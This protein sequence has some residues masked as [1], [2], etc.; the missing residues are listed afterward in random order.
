MPWPHPL[1]LNRDADVNG[2]PTTHGLPLLSHWL[3]RLSAGLTLLPSDHS[4][5]G[6]GDRQLTE[7]K[8][9]VGTELLPLGLNP[10]VL[11]LGWL[12]G[13]FSRTSKN[14]GPLP[15]RRWALTTKHTVQK[16]LEA[17]GEARLHPWATSALHP[18][19]VHAA[20]GSVDLSGPVLRGL[21]ASHAGHGLVL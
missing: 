15:G 11:A 8:L 17:P 3:T 2:S 6:T 5:E 14:R 9:A 18:G 16:K 21:W 1:G 12:R 4:P 20:G 10:L 7:N 19:C 13:Q